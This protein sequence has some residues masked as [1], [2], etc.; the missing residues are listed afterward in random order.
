[1]HSKQSKQKWAQLLYN[2][3]Q[4]KGEQLLHNKQQTEL[5]GIHW[6]LIK[7]KIAGIHSNLREPIIS[8]HL[9]SIHEAFG[10]LKLLICLG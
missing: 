5:S 7:N 2:K 10:V 1:M 6:N 9:E 3:Q 4:T 8:L